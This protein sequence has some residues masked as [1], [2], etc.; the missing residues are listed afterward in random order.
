MHS[1]K[2]QQNTQFLSLAA[3]K[4]TNKG[5]KLQPERKFAFFCVENIIRSLIVQRKTQIAGSNVLIW[6][7]DL[8][9][10]SEKIG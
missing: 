9:R 6:K 4:S 10:K 2:A 5:Y 3:E 7:Q 1:R 8:Y